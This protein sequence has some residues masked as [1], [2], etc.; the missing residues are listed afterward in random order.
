MSAHPDTRTARRRR[1]AI[2]WACPR[3][4]DNLRGACNILAF[5]LCGT[6]KFLYLCKTNN[7]LL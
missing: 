7:G 3:H 5:F 4:A 2:V 1:T 6:D